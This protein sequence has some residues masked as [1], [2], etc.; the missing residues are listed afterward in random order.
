MGRLIGGFIMLVVMCSGFAS[1]FK[2][3]RFVDCD[4]DMKEIGIVYVVLGIILVVCGAIA[5]LI[6]AGRIA[7][8]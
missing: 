1:T 3:A 2:G 7:G 6:L 4:G 5:L 8:L